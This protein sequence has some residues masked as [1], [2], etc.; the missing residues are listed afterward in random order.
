MPCSDGRESFDWEEA[1]DNRHMREGAEL[2][3]GWLKHIESLG[4]YPGVPDWAKD[5]WEKHKER[6]ARREI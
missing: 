3:C 6:D 2:L 1:E 4:E 5:W